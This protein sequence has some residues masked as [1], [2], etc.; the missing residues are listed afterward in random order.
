MPKRVASAIDGLEAVGALAASAIV[1][2]AQLHL[3]SF[4]MNRVNGIFI[5]TFADVFHCDCYGSGIAPARLP[6]VPIRQPRILQRLVPLRQDQF[7]PIV[8]RQYLLR[9]AVVRSIFVNGKRE[10]SAA[11]ATVQSQIAGVPVVI[12][13]NAPPEIDR[14]GLGHINHWD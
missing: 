1:V 3:A 4:S 9:P 10:K 13:I 7:L 8:N 11:V 12:L 2:D 5:E 6:A 14:W